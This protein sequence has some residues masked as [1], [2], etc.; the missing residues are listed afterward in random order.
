[1]ERAPAIDVINVTE[2]VVEAMVDEVLREEQM[3]ACRQC[4]LDVMAIALNSLPPKYVAT[5]QGNA[6]E[7]YRLQGV[8]QSR[9]TVYQ[10]ILRAAQTVKQRPHH[11][12]RGGSPQG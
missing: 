8:T 7:T 3:C 9:I 6:Y 1:M 4:R 11:G 10:T 2:G 5:E 12:E